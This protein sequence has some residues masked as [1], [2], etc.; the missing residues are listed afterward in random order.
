MLNIEK[1]KELK[2]QVFDDFQLYEVKM[3]N[4]FEESMREVTPTGEMDEAGN[5]LTSLIDAEIA[6]QSVKSEDVQMAIDQVEGTRRKAQKKL[7]SLIETKSRYD[8]QIEIGDPWNWKWEESWHPLAV[9]GHKQT[10]KNANL[11]IAALQAY[12]PWVSVEVEKPE[13]GKH[14]LLC[15]EVR[16]SGKRYVCD[17]Y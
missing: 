6:R 2:Q 16:P 14:V 3:Q 10:I 17:R 4:S 1:L 11:V 7:D 8:H 9:E 5:D 12:Q 13:S 15:C